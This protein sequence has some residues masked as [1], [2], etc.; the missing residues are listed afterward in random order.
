[1][2]QKLPENQDVI[3]LFNVNVLVFSSIVKMKQMSD[4]SKNSLN[5]IESFEKGENSNQTIKSGK[6]YII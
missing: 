5:V 1:M 2:K 4:K 6:K 3:D